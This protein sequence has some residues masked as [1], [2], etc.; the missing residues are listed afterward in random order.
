LFNYIVLH[1]EH[2]R[3]L[4]YR[5]GIIEELSSEQEEAWGDEF[6][7]GKTF[8]IKE[9]LEEGYRGVL[10]SLVKRGKAVIL[11]SERNNKAGQAS[12]PA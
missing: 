6:S 11:E 1:F 4:G 2:N 5:V 8:E 3:L 12:E 10:K 7:V 9:Q